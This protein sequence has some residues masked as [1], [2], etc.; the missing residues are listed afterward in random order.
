[1]A[2]SRKL[3]VRLAGDFKIDLSNAEDD[4]KAYNTI[5]KVIR[6][7]V[8]PALKADNPAFRYDTFFAAC[9]LDAFGERHKP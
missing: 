8:A 2:A 5:A 3:Y 1:M 4:L 6:E 7:T 9:G